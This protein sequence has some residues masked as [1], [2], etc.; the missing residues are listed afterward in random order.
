MKALFAHD[1]TFFRSGDAYYSNGGLSAKVLERYLQYFNELVLLTRQAESKVDEGALTLAS[2]SGK[3]F[4]A[5]PNFKSPRLLLK[6]YLPALVIVEQAVKNSD[7]VIARMPSAIASL[8]IHYA[9]K[10]KKPYVVEVVGCVW[11]ANIQH[12]S[13]VGKLIAPFEY[14]KT[15]KLI[16][17]S[18]YVIYITQ[19]FLQ[20]R[21]PT[22]AAKKEVC[23]NVSIGNVHDEVL[24]ARL[25]KIDRLDSNN[26]V[27]GLIGSLAVGYKGHATIIKAL[28]SLRQRFPGIQL[29]FLG[30]GDPSRWLSMAKALGTDDCVRFVGSLPAGEPVNKWLDGLDIVAQPSSAEAQGR[31]IIESMSRGCPIVSTQIGGIVELLDPHWLVPSDDSK[32]LA[33]QLIELIGS[34]EKMKEQAALNFMKAKN[35]SAERIESKRHAFFADFIESELGGKENNG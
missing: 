8:A 23:P 7:C 34:K 6:N 16:E 21:Y 15:R 28:P 1:H 18:K 24:V 22:K 20:D 11:D 35:Y 30:K 29:R 31:S 14:F 13:T 10:H 32:L 17:N 2:G 26:V 9:K 4:I 12:G 3:T 27:I 5:V 25:N 19:K 33:H